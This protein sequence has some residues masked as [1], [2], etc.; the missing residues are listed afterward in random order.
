MSA[1]T[2]HSLGRRGAGG[3]LGHPKGRKSRQGKHRHAFHR[4]GDTG[5]TQ[6]THSTPTNNTCSIYHTGTAYNPG[7][8]KKSY[9]MQNHM[10]ATRC[11]EIHA[12]RP[13]HPAKQQ[14]RQHTDTRTYVNTSPP[15]RFSHVQYAKGR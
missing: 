13:S 5:D 10:N 3:R 4:D 14:Q 1:E 7:I 12:T 6:R 2:G 9:R 8:F 11:T 15:G